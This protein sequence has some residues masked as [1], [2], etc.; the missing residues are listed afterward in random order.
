MAADI[1][2][3]FVIILTLCALLIGARVEAA[4]PTA[5]PAASAPSSSRDYRL[6]AGDTVSIQVFNEPELSITVKIG[7]NGRVAYPFLGE[8]SV[9]GT[10]PAALEKQI[11]AALEGDYL[12]DPRVSVSITEYRPFFVNGQV[13]NPGSFPFQPGM[14]VRKAVSLAGG[15]TERASDKRITLIPEQQRD[16]QTG[17]KVG[18][19]DPVGPGD[20]VTVEESFF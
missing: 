14:T 18:M 7:D 11:A 20:I 12:V 8:L 1:R 5:S 10:T 16:S 13:K 4:T 6:G 9:A 2:T 19:D 17:H 15:L 3:G